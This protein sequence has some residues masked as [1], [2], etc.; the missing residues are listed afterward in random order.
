MMW[1]NLSFGLLSRLI[2]IIV[3]FFTIGMAMKAIGL[4]A[5]WIVATALS[6]ITL[7]LMV[8]AASTAGLS[9]LLIEYQNQPSSFGALYVT[10]LTAFLCMGLV[11]FALGGLFFL[12]S[13]SPIGDEL[14]VSLGGLIFT[15]I[16]IPKYAALYAADRLDLQFKI[17]IATALGKLALI[18]LLFAGEHLG[19]F[20]FCTVLA[21]E[22]MMI[23]LLVSLQFNRI[24]GEEKLPSTGRWFYVDEFRKAFSFNAWI[25]VNSL[26]QSLIITAPQILLHGA[27]GSRSLSVYGVFL[28]LHNFSRG[29]VVSLNASVVTRSSLDYDDDPEAYHRM[30]GK[31]AV[32]LAAFSVA[33][34][35]AFLAAGDQALHL[36]LGIDFDE[37]TLFLLSLLL[38]TSLYASL[39]LVFGNLSVTS[40]RVKPP[41]LAGFL[42]A[43]IAV[44]ALIFLE[45][46]GVQSLSHYAY[47]VALF[48]VIYVMTKNIVTLYAL[49]P[50]LSLTEKYKQLGINALALAVMAVFLAWRF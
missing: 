50:I 19:T 31:S 1:K 9:R 2:Q 24:V 8:Q 12:Y 46:Q 25:S 11:A 16:A 28:Q 20:T 17:L 32:G 36:W 5:W 15:L 23:Y 49:G 48:Q 6:V 40:K 7:L 30:L 10:A 39:S 42:I 33:G 47:G 14:L 34:F 38:M 41:A 29:F 13:S 22:Q 26:S 44:A 45:E 18:S 43:V 35:L 27:V 3:S 37:P 4:D 21:F